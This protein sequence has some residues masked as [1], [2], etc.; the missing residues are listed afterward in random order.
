M[1]WS[2]KV[3]N[4]ESLIEVF[5]YNNW[6]NEFNYMLDIYQRILKIAFNDNPKIN[7]MIDLNNEG[8]WTDIYNLFVKEKTKIMGYNEFMKI[9]EFLF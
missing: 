4:H 5:K 6:A 1:G 8:T 7:D 9:I 3:S 2:S